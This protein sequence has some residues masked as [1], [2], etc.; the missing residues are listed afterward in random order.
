[1]LFFVFLYCF[2]PYVMLLLNYIHYKKVR[3]LWNLM[4]NY[5]L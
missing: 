1:L 3:L 2:L 4:K 5:T